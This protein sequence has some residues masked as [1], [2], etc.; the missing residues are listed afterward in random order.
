M[1]KGSEYHFYSGGYDSLKPDYGNIFTGYRVNVSNLGLSTDPRLA[2]QLKEVS[3]KLSSGQKA[4]EV[5]GVIPK[6]FASI[7]KEEIKEINRLSQLTGVEVSMHAPIVE[8]SGI[9]QQGGFSEHTRLEAEREMMHIVD[10]SRDLDPKGNVTINFHSSGESVVRAAE[11]R[12]EGDKEIIER[13]VVLDQETGQVAQAK[14][15]IYQRPGMIHPETHKVIDLDEGKIMEIDDRIATMNASDWDAEI[16]KLIAPKEQSDKLFQETIPL[17]QVIQESKVKREHLTL[18]QKEVLS[19]YQ[20]AEILQ[21]DVKKHL[22]GLFERAYKFGTPK[23]RE[24]LNQLSKEYAE[25]IHDFD[26]S[27]KIKVMKDE[28]GNPT[29]YKKSYFDPRMRSELLQKM[30]VRLSS[31]EFVPERFKPIEEFAIDKS[32]KTFGNVAFYGWESSKDKKKAPIVEI[33]NP[34]A[35]TFGLSR[36]ED[37]RKL[38][39]GAKEQ[40]KKR[41]ME[42]KGM[43]EKE[44]KRL[45]DKHIGLTWDV[46]HINNL[47][48]FGFTDKDLVKEAEAV[49]PHLSKIHLADNFG[50]VDAELPMGMGNVPLQE[51]LKALGEKGVKAKK[52]IETG[53]WWEHFKV[54]PV[55]ASLQAL[56][57]PIYEVGMGPY[58]DQTPA[59]HEQGYF[60]GYG[61]LLPS[62]NYQ[63]WGAGFSRLPG[64]LG[65]SAG[66]SGSNF[67]GRPME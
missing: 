53:D 3:T 15:E 4:I 5:S 45:A 38:A 41:A 22:D 64:E 63:T 48:K 37:L 33:E 13:M 65:G 60:S 12:K 46:G 42:E 40:F 50:M 16:T 7:P 32:A 1:A 35:G 30:I 61:E 57:S 27:G 54:S 36:G 43:S 62:V 59:L 28:A 51:T 20:N 24:K 8:P 2:N 26:S 66:Q 67:S 55:K 47:R 49:A 21:D 31:N 17:V 56:G 44:A 25:E 23:A 52:I 58:W 14:R 9:A 34:P 6:V 10:K 18:P 29:I 19:R 11:I 39:V